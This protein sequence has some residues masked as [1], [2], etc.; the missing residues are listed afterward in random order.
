MRVPHTI[1]KVILRA[2]TRTLNEDQLKKSYEGRT[3]ISEDPTWDKDVTP[4]LA[5]QC[6]D[7]VQDEFLFYHHL[8][9]YFNNKKLEEYEFRRDNWEKSLAEY[10]EKRALYEKRLIAYQ[11]RLDGYGDTGDFDD[12]LDDTVDDTEQPTVDANGRP[13]EPEKIDD[14]FA[15][16]EP[17]PSILDTL[18]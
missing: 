11:S 15:Q 6:L 1:P 4:T 8:L 16:Y 2:Y 3:L 7:L 17:I 12:L 14:E 10:V 18:K 9:E 5:Q 13:L